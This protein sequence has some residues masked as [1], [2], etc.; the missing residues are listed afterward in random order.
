MYNLLNLAA[1]DLIVSTCNLLIDS[2]WYV[3]CVEF[4]KLL[5]L[6][7]VLHFEA[8]L[9]ILWDNYVYSAAS[10]HNWFREFESYCSASKQ[11]SKK[12]TFKLV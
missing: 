5:F 10:K 4:L 12:N 8:A 9:P 7:N 2:Q 1:A 3:Y 11:V 6:R